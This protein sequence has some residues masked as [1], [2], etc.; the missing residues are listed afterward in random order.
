MGRNPLLIGTGIY[1]IHAVI[2]CVQIVLVS[3][4]ALMVLAISV[5]NAGLVR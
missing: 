5:V 1:V 3:I 4:K 2:E